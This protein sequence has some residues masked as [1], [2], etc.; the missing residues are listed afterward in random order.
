MIERCKDCGR[1]LPS[2]GPACPAQEYPSLL[3]EQQIEPQPPTEQ[4][5]ARREAKAFIKGEKK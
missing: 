1:P 2:H 4:Y 5:R 3:I